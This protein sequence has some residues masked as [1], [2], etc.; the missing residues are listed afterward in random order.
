M[1]GA[2]VEA[3]NVFDI[4]SLAFDLLDIPVSNIIT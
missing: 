2:R 3:R 1:H 4:L